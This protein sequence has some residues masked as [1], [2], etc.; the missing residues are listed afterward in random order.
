LQLWERWDAE[1]RQL[2]A[3]VL[4]YYEV[5]NALYR[6]RRMGL[7][8]PASMRLALQTAPPLP[9]RLYQDAGL[10]RRAPDPAERFGLPAA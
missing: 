6:Y 4:L 10:H 7:M 3:P 5:T 8:S 1:G 2:V 9:L